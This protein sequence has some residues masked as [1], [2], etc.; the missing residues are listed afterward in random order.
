MIAIRNEGRASVD[1]VAVFWVTIVIGIIVIVVFLVS[2][3][4]K[5]KRPNEFKKQTPPRGGYTPPPP[6]HISANRPT[7]YVETAIFNGDKLTYSGHS[8]ESRKQSLLDTYNAP[9]DTFT[10]TIDDWN[11]RAREKSEILYRQLQAENDSFDPYSPIAPG[12]YSEEPLISTEKFFLQKIHG[13]P[14][15]HP[16]IA[17][18]WFWEYNISF[19]K[20]MIRLMGCGYLRVSEIAED[21]THFKVDEMRAV[22][23]KANLPVSGKK[24]ELLKRITDNIPVLELQ[25]FIQDYPKH[26]ALTDKGRQ[27]IKGLQKSMTKN[28]E[29]EDRCMKAILTGNIQ[30]AYKTVCAYEA[31]KNGNRGVGIDWNKELDTGLSFAK[32]NL[33]RAFMETPLSDHLMSGEL[34]WF[35]P[36]IKASVVLGVML[37]NTAPNI[38]LLA[39][40]FS[41]I[42]IREK[43]K[44]TQLTYKLL[45]ALMEGRLPR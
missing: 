11:R 42:N 25:A 37:G 1:P 10:G 33:F 20:I 28:H 43:T 22:L 12:T 8:A 6:Q 9:I 2:E 19:P 13:K 18:Y 45:F 32:E 29:L 26:Y 17:G 7:E 40:R 39:I 36:Q 21:I 4:K 30:E 35:E 15:K 16:E 14:I 5:T 44:L 27:A 31:N 24:A 38:T 3:H 23:R 41:G 34:P